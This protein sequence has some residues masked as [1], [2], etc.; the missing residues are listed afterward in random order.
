M[1]SPPRRQLEATVKN[2]EAGPA[3]FQGRRV[4]PNVVVDCGWG[5]LIFAHTFKGPKEVASTLLEERPGRRDIAFYSRDPHVVLALH[6]HKLFLDPSHTFRL[7]LP[8]YQSIAKPIREFE[9]T[10]I[11]SEADAMGLNRIYA[12]RGM[13]TV[14]SD[15]LMKHRRSRTL[16]Y[17]V[18]KDPM[19]HEVIGVIMG[20]NH[21]LLFDDPE[22]G[23][24]IWSLAV[25]PQTH[26]PGIGEA[27]IRQSAE[28]MKSRGCRYVDLSVFHD[29]REAIALYEKLGF[30]R[31]PA[32]VVKTRNTINEK[33]FSG[34]L[35]DQRLN[36]YATII[37]NEARRR[38][39]DI[40]VLDPEAGYFQ[41]T[42]G[43]RS[44][45]CRESLS[46]LT[47]AIA[48][49]RCADK[50]LTRRVLQE[51][52]LSVP[53]QMMADGRKKNDVFLR[54]YQSIVVKPV[55]GEQGIGVSVD[56]RRAKEMEAAIAFAGRLG[57]RVLLEQYVKGEDLR[58]VLI[59][60]EV[61]AAAVRRPPRITGTGN[62]TIA[63]LIERQS[64]RRARLTGGES[65]IPLDGETKRCLKEHGYGLSDILPKGKVISARKTA[66]LH[67]G[68][69]IHDV[70][71]KIN[72]GLAAAAVIGAEALAIPVV[73]LDFIVE[74]ISKPRYV[75]IEANERPGLAN[76]E[77]QPT[78]ERFIDL[79]FPQTKTPTTF[80]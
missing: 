43:G 17:L 40:D 74:N 78:A 35:P 39:I 73:G 47:S 14:D 53:A 60:Y 2:W 57:D 28:Q 24:S 20:V 66:N 15:F 76:H 42:F 63:Q 4:K 23:S 56:I 26:H 33:L 27:L 19:T 10:P 68:G 8:D 1:A 79:L 48:M 25:D 3:M 38:G 55:T 80:K 50:M 30:Y 21:R 12:A 34:P 41:L 22:K 5:R 64:Q 7:W 36:P 49:S 31:I 44:I 75:I 9:I 72:P 51:A 29:N 11:Q 77:P 69:T 59:N 52:G 70:T 37:V 16:C 13:V 65:R 58:I 61:V 62:H 18:A 32:F 67:T 6:P 45:T 54:Q 71:A 46:E